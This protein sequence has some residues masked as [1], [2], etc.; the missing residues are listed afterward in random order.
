MSKRE[1]TV[2]ANF[3]ARTT[4]HARARIVIDECNEVHVYFFVL[5]F[6]DGRMM[7]IIVMGCSSDGR[8]TVALVVLSSRYGVQETMNHKASFGQHLLWRWR[9]DETNGKCAYFA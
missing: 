5:A 4:V 6:C 3:G 9:L 7:I 8:D 1:F 2:R